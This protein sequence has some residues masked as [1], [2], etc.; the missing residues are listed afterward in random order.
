MAKRKPTPR[1]DIFCADCIRFRR[2]TEGSNYSRITRE[3]FMG[4]CLKGLQP[5]NMSKVFANKPRKK[6]DNY[7][8][9]N[10]NRQA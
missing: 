1:T 8:P 9:D 6:C 7:E 2:D 4:V 3:Y 5:D 10:N